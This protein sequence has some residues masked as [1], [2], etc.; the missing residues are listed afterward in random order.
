ML[1]LIARLPKLERLLFRY[2][3]GL[4][5]RPNAVQVPFETGMGQVW[6]KRT[7]PNVKEVAIHTHSK[8]LLEH[9]P[10]VVHVSGL[11]VRFNQRFQMVPEMDYDYW[12]AIAGQQHLMSIEMDLYPSYAIRE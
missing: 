8:G 2:I 7:F 3:S 10:N 9:F 12:D 6:T 1:D 5:N 4:S 11:P